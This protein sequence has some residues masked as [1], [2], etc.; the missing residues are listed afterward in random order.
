MDGIRGKQREKES[1]MATIKQ[2][3]ESLERLAERAG[4]GGGPEIEYDPTDYDGQYDDRDFPPDEE[5]PS[6]EDPEPPAAR[7]FAKTATVSPTVWI[8]GEPRVFDRAKVLGQAQLLG[9][10]VIIRDR[11]V[12]KDRAVIE[13]SPRHGRIGPFIG[14]SAKIVGETMIYGDIMISGGTWDFPAEDVIHPLRGGG[15]TFKSPESYIKARD[16][17]Q[18]QWRDSLERV[19]RDQAAWKSGH[20]RRRAKELLR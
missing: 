10:G 15:N 1:E 2:L 12:V 13:S 6:G 19:R 7:L 8:S 4:Y 17:A 20:R 9:T 16:R 14:G 11:A 5:D 3:I 18:Q